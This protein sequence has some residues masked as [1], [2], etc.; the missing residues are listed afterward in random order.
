MNETRPDRPSVAMRVVGPAA[1]LARS[2]EGEPREEAMD[3]GVPV[4][5]EADRV[6]VTPARE[7]LVIDIGYTDRDRT[8]AHR[9]GLGAA[10]I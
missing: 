4:K 7:R 8:L 9:A 3:P 1:Q 6:D 5:H 10:G 2:F